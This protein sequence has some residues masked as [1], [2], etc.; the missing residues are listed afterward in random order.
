MQQLLSV[1]GFGAEASARPESSNLSL[2]SLCALRPFDLKNNDGALAVE[3][4]LE[5]PD[6]RR[7]GP[8]AGNSVERDGSQHSFTYFQQV[9]PASTA[10]RFHR[11][12]LTYRPRAAWA[13]VLQDKENVFR[14]SSGPKGR[15]GPNAAG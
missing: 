10:I 2:G 4:R 3:E 13:M 5:N 6:A 7:V 8:S 12:V 14:T 9:R 15:A 1:P 11:R